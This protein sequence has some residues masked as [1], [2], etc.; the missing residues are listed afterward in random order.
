[1]S[2]KPTGRCLGCGRPVRNRLL[3]AD[4][5]RRQRPPPAKAWCPKCGGPLVATTA[6]C[7]ACVVVVAPAGAPVRGPSETA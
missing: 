3:C 2:T 4:C 6:G 5:A 1:M 7:P